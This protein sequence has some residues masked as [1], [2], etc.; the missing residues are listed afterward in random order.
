LL[1]LLVL[2]LGRCGLEPS[3]SD[4]LRFCYHW[5]LNNCWLPYGVLKLV[6]GVQQPKGNGVGKFGFALHLDLF[7]VLE[8]FFL[9]LDK[10]S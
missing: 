2:W 5:F 4:V 7:F 8:S 9:A 10:L 6:R 1:P 3:A